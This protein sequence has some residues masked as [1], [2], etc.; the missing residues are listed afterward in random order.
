MAKQISYKSL[1][2]AIKSESQ[3]NETFVQIGDGDNLVVVSVKKTIPVHLMTAMIN[4]IV[5]TLFIANEDGILSYRPM[6]KDIVIC[7]K[8]L[9]Y[10]TNIKSDDV[11]RVDALLYH[12]DIFEKVCAQISKKQLDTIYESVNEL[13]Y[14]Y[15]SYMI[16]SKS[17][18]IKSIM[19]KFDRASDVLSEMSN[20]LQN[21]DSTSLSKFMESF[22]NIDGDDLVHSVLSFRGKASQDA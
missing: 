3:Q 12:T 2:A 10:Y 7:S 22:A 14:V 4:E 8:I 15:K 11:D 1:D 13:I 17:Y 16:D 18:S 9:G 6:W 20:V 19:N 21:I 5:D